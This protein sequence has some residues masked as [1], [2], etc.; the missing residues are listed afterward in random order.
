[1][2]ILHRRLP[3]LESTA[4][5]EVDDS[6]HGGEVEFLAIAFIAVDDQLGGSRE[7]TRI[8]RESQL[9]R[10]VVW[11]NGTTLNVDCAAGA[12][13]GLQCQCQQYVPCRLRKIDRGVTANEGDHR[14]VPKQLVPLYLKINGFYKIN[15]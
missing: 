9:A 15:L 14:S 1:M 13:A 10:T 11:G 3:D 2:R 5:Q 12:P 6:R 4:T 7:F 8:T